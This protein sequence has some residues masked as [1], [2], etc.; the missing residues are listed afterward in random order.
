MVYDRTMPQMQSGHAQPT[1]PECLIP[2]APPV[3]GCPFQPR[4][5][6]HPGFPPRAPAHLVLN[7]NAPCPPAPHCSVPGEHVRPRRPR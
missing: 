6:D 3:K 5:L 7:E 4:P 1:H 2:E